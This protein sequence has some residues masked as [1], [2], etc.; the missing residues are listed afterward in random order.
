MTGETGAGKDAVARALHVLSGRGAL[1]FVTIDCPG[2]PPSLLEAELFGHERGAF[3]DA[4]TDRAGRFEL[5]GAGTVYSIG[6]HELPLDLQAKLLRIVE[7]KQ[8]E[9]LGSVAPLPVQARIIASADDKVEDVGARR[10]LPRRTCIT[11]CGCCRC[12]FR[13][14]GSG[15]PTCCRSRGAMLREIGDRDGTGR[16]GAGARRHRS[17]RRRTG[18]RAT[19]ASSR[20]CSSVASSPTSADVLVADDLPIEVQDTARSA[21]PR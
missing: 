20:T 1:P 21:A 7:Q 14:C 18:G 8:V 12:A 13:R 5:A 16:P 2:I 19:C 11:G 4:T 6:V 10:P 9:R 17:D 15:A 3:T